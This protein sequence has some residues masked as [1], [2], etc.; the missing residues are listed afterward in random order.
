MRRGV[1]HTGCGH[2]CT[3][4]ARTLAK[5]GMVVTP[6]IAAPA[7]T[8]AAAGTS[9]H[10]APRSNSSPKVDRSGLPK[11]RA[12]DHAE[13]VQTAVSQIVGTVLTVWVFYTWY[14]MF[15]FG[16]YVP[17]TPWKPAVGLMQ[18]LVCIV[19]VPAAGIATVLLGAIATRV[20]L[21]VGLRAFRRMEF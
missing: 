1:W 10:A 12:R 4:H 9:S 13:R 3:K 11:L 5:R 18:I 8:P 14:Q 15:R 7:P 2:A 21:G 16:G 20:P 6:L 17:L 19:I